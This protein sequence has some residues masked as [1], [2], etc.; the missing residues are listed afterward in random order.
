MQILKLSY[1][2][3]LL[4]LVMLSFHKASTA[5]QFD[6][7]SKLKVSL[8]IDSDKLSRQK[9]ARVTITIENLSDQELDIKSVGS[10]ELLSKRAEAV[11]RKHSVFGDSYWSPVNVSTGAPKQLDIIDPELQKKG[12]VVGRV[13][14]ET[15]RFGATEVKTFTLD[16]TKTLWNASMGNDWPRWNLFEVVSKGE[17][18]LEFRISSSGGSLKSNAVPIAIK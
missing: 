10:F 9:P 18:F 1:V 4:L 6:N 11:A 3:A 15:L 5:Q 13:P 2:A 7:T 17:Y 16:P 14:E 12:V 8:T